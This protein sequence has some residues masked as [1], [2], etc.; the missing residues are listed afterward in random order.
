MTS[1]F[2]QKL[3]IF[4]IDGTLSLPQHRLHFLD[5]KENP[6]RWRDFYAACDLDEPNK[7]VIMVMNSLLLSGAEVWLFS[8][9]SDEVMGETV[10]W[11]HKHVPLLML[12][13]GVIMMRPAGDSTPDDKLK[14]SW[15][16]NM[17]IDD[18]RRLVGVFDDRN[19]VVNM[20]RSK[21]VPCFQVAP[22]DF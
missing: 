9:R 14:E 16:E 21:G 1:R 6:H 11:L 5:D 19:R 18:Q 7:P 2:K 22:G 17:L 8:G 15:Y 10:D 13:P 3:F 12:E 20:W 4:D